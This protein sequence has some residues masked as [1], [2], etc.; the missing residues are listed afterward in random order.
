M[1]RSYFDRLIARSAGE[2]RAPQATPRALRQPAREPL[3][4]P[5]E[6]VEPA[7]DDRSGPGL[8][9]APVAPSASLAPAPP[10]VRAPAP[11]PP[12]A[13]ARMETASPPMAGPPGRKDVAPGASP[14][15]PVRQTPDEPRV[16][17]RPRAEARPSPQPERMLIVRDRRPP[18]IEAA[19]PPV[20]E[21]APASSPEPSIH[22]LRAPT[23]APPQ[24]LSP[25]VASP[26]REEPS[27]RP[28]AVEPRLPVDVHMVSSE[29]S[30]TRPGAPPELLP[31]PPEPRAVEPSPDEPR[32]TIGRVRVEVV[33]VS[34]PRNPESRPAPRPPSPLRAERR[35]VLSSKLRFGLGQS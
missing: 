5:F 15:P 28:P 21:P 3:D 22:S 27:A 10:V 12:P 26:P 23:P 6:R 8:E 33:P 17:P 1:T 9:H 35:G 4:D 19:R 24:P 32:I 20:R 31:R 7:A 30:G 29:R 18:S 13:P 34:R 25:P 16:E 14:P 11:V 2:A